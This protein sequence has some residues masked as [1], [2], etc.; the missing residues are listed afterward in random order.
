MSA[1]PG[2]WQ[3]LDGLQLL[4]ALMLLAL[5]LM[6]VYSAN[7]DFGRQL[8][9]V[10]LGLIGFAVAA[11]FDYRRLRSVAT[12]LYC[13]CL[14]LLVAVALAGHSALG[15]RRWLSVGGFPLEPSEVS[16]LL[17]VAVLAALLSRRRPAT[18]APGGGR[19]GLLPWP[20]FLV[21]GGLVAV[22][23]ALILAQPDLGT[24]IVFVGV[25]AGMLF[26]A[27]ARRLQ[28]AWA[29][30]ASAV[31]LP[32]LPLLLRGYQRRRLQVFLDPSQD[33][34]GAGYNLIQAR[35]AVGSGGLFGQGWLHGVQGQLG[36]VPERATDFIFA[37]YAEQFGL[38]GCLLLLALFG[39]LILRLAWTVAVAPDGFGALLAAGVAAMFLIQLV[40]NVGMNVGLLP[41]AGIPL[42]LVSY[43]GSAMITD[44]CA[45]GLAQSVV[46]RRRS[47]QHR[48][49]VRPADELVEPSTVRLPV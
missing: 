29:L 41:I 39:V 20:D 11:A 32:L 28:V 23:A 25:L 36:F 21:A 42:P 16:K 22:P 26:L 4:A 6:T 1:R 35:I 2:L 44:L 19:W 3:R 8:L 30:A 9:W 14:L 46:L 12:A 10:A 33:P 48:A 34:L 38:L 31:L 15:A 47:V 27:G 13:G 7:V 5:G 17:M 37:V 40:E 49:P 45:L 24:A 43:G 18:S